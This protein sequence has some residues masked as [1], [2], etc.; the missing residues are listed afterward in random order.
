MN[1][2]LLNKNIFKKGLSEI[3]YLIVTQRHLTT[4]LAIKLNS[5]DSYFTDTTVESSKQLL[6]AMRGQQMLCS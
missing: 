1:G 4:K 5:F 2:N 3:R 6:I